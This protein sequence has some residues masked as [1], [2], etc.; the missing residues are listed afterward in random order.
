LGCVRVPVRYTNFGPCIGSPPPR[1]PRARADA[2]YAESM[3]LMLP[4]LDHRENPRLR[5][6]RLIG[7]RAEKLVR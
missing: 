1:V 7:I 6:V 2:L 3:R 5:K 4:F